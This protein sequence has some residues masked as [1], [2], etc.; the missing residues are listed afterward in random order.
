ME[1]MEAHLRGH[2]LQANMI[3][4]I[5]IPGTAVLVQI[6]WWISHPSFVCKSGYSTTG[7]FNFS[8]YYPALR[9]FL[10]YIVEANP[11]KRLQHMLL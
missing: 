10:G 9:T 6:T 1:Q 11:V 7:S 4:I 8:A 3:M 5:N 2:W